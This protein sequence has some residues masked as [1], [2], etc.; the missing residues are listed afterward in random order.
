MKADERV[1]V[2]GEDGK[3]RLA[4]EELSVTIYFQDEGEMWD[5]EEWLKGEGSKSFAK[6]RGSDR[7]YPEI[8][9]NCKW[10]DHENFQC[11]DGHAQYAE[12]EECE[13]F[14]EYE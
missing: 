14:E 12:R 5:F 9:Y 4:D 3:A 11:F 6:Y 7:E 13:G 8:C 2:I 1:F 10:F